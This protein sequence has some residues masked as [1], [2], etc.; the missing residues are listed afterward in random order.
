MPFTNLQAS[1]YISH[2][3]SAASFPGSGS[4]TSKES[5]FVFI[6]PCNPCFFSV[7]TMPLWNRTETAHTVFNLQKGTVPCSVLFSVPFLIIL[8]AWY[9]LPSSTVTGIGADIF[10][11]R[12]CF[13]L[14]FCSLL[15]SQRFP[16]FFLHCV[17]FL[18]SSYIRQTASCTA[19]WRPWPDDQG[20]LLCSSAPGSSLGLPSLRG[21]GKAVAGEGCQGAESPMRR[22]C[23]SWAKRG[24]CKNQHFLEGLLQRWQSRQFLSSGKGHNEGPHIATME[25]EVGH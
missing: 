20:K 1:F 21:K 12:T 19:L 11:K 5:F 3:H 13:N 4:M 8:L 25:T 6:Y 2:F 7:F 22:G 17:T 23:R 24:C 10:I 15:T 16:T 18:F 14:T 9:L